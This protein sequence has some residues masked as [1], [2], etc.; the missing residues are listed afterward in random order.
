MRC[1]AGSV[2]GGVVEP[3]AGPAAC[4]LV[5]ENKPEIIND[6]TLIPMGSVPLTYKGLADGVA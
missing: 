5:M 2:V 4:P 1:W 3:G 6:R